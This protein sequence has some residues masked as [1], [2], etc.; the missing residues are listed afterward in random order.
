MRCACKHIFRELAFVDSKI[1]SLEQDIYFYLNSRYYY[2][3]FG[4]MFCV[5]YFMQ[6]M[7]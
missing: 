5:L 4:T 2:I 6:H 7:C 3:I 1:F